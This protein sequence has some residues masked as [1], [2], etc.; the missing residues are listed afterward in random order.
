VVVA[1]H[2]GG[3]SAARKRRAQLRA[4]DRPS[5]CG[6]SRS[7][8][9]CVSDRE[10][11]PTGSR[12]L[13]HLGPAGRA[14]RS[15]RGLI[16]PVPPRERAVSWCELRS[17][18]PDAEPELFASKAD[19][20]RR[21]PPKAGHV[22]QA[23]TGTLLARRIADMPFRPGQDRARA[24]GSDVERVG[25]A[26]RSRSTCV[27]RLP[28]KDLAAECRPALP[29]GSVL[30]VERG[31]DPRPRPCATARGTPVA[32][33]HFRYRAASAAGLGA[34]PFLRFDRRAPGL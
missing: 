33:S 7:S 34:Q 30:S 23:R 11:A 12:I 27:H 25:A 29:R 26:P 17:M 4:G 6:A 9:R 1:R 21:L 13:I 10:V 15:W 32:A 28:N 20:T 18:L 31:A 24:A 14:R 2:R 3:A 16:Q 5:L 19:P 22:E 8:I